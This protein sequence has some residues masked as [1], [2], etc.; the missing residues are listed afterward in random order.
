MQYYCR[1]SCTSITFRL[2]EFLESLLY[3]WRYFC[4]FI[5]LNGCVCCDA[6]SIPAN[7]HCSPVQVVEVVAVAATAASTA[8]AVAVA[9]VRLFNYSHT[10]LDGHDVTHPHSKCKCDRLQLPKIRFNICI[11]CVFKCAT[12]ANSPVFCLI[13]MLLQIDSR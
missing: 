12:K 8:I 9:I 1:V 11:C 3:F 2:L 10:D 13:R 7:D 4:V 5:V 6:K